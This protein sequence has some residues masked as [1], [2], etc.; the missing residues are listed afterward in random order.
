[1]SGFFFVRVAF[2][3]VVFVR[4]GGGGGFVRIPF[5]LIAPQSWLLGNLNGLFPHQVHHSLVCWLS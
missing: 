4:G 1:M 3:R 2:V 5:N